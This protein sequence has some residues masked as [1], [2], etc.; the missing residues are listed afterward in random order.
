MK[1]LISIRKNIRKNNKTKITNIISQPKERPVV[2]VGRH[3]NL[4][5][6]QL[7]SLNAINATKREIGQSYVEHQVNENIQILM[8]ITKLSV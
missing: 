7:I 3:V 5:T 2:N 4:E 8:Q 6:V 1:R